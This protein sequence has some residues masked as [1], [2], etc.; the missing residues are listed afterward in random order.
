MSILY[1]YPEKLI[2]KPNLLHICRCQDSADV[3]ECE[4][5]ENLQINKNG[6]HY[7]ED[8][9]KPY[10]MYSGESEDES[11]VPP[12]ATPTPNDNVIKILPECTD[13]ST[14]TDWQDALVSYYLLK[15]IRL[16]AIISRIN[17]SKKSLL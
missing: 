14:Q 13:T 2:Q 5:P 12:L 6:V 9:V 11:K 17:V 7:P 1:Y 3:C 16:Q 4:I 15:Y 10:R 8:E